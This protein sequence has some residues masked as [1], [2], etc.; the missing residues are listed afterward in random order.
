MNFPFL[1]MKLEALQRSILSPILYILFPLDLPTFA[2][3][4]V[5]IVSTAI[6]LVKKIAHKANELMSAHFTF[7]TKR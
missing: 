4:T 1:A 5:V 2:D 3:V 6:R 7:S